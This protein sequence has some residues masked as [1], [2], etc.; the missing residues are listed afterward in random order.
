MIHKL[1]QLLTNGHPRSVKAKKNILFTFGLKGISILIN[2][3]YVPLLI[4]Y[5]GTEEYGVWLTVSSVVA[6][7]GFFDIGLGNGLRN[8][9]SMAVARGEHVLARKYVSTTYAILAIIC[10]TVLAIFY[11]V[12]GFIHWPGVFNTAHV[13]N[14]ILLNL[15]LI[16][17]TFFFL[18]FVFQ[19]IGVILLADQ[20][21]SVNSSFNVISNILCF[22]IIYLLKQSA[23]HSLP[24][25]GLVLSGMPVFVL[26][27]ASLI[28]YSTRYRQ[29]APALRFVDFSQSATLLNL[30]IKFF[31]LQVSGL[32]MYSSTNLLI[33]QFSSPA[34]V[35]VYNI[36]Y[37]LFSV[38]T[39]IYGIILTPM[40]SATTEAFA[41][42]DYKWIRNTVRKMQWLGFGLIAL[43]FVV[44]MFSEKIY[45]LWVGNR[46]HIPFQVSALVSL[47]AMLY[48][49]TGIYV[50]FQN[51]IGK[52]KLTLYIT[53]A[54]TL[55]F[56]PVAYFFGKVL[57]IGFI[58]IL[59]ASL[60]CDLPVKY[61]QIRQYYKII[62]HKAQGI[63]NQ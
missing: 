46:V 48:V 5:L 39:M 51:G 58:G 40:W 60:I 43:L 14:S 53:V 7:F 33:A 27:V 23:Q 17:F 45:F 32:V 16:V 36:S 13:E 15:S 63:W 19:L 31:I 6:W 54:V 38:A 2:L 37:K 12:S 29:Y 22:G 44:L 11:A 1:N 4:D 57:G 34:D 61:I 35:T 55:L 28:L 8:N 41:L 62:N 47:S 24:I 25:L 18:N 20:K 10:I 56:L 42:E 50:A 9:F 26:V 3:A 21:P 52:I 49:L 30:G 59:L